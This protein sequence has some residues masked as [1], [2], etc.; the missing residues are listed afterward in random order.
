VTGKEKL[1]AIYADE[2]VMDLGLAQDFC[3]ETSIYEP[4]LAKA[5]VKTTEMEN[6]PWFHSLVMTHPLNWSSLKKN[7]ILLIVAA[8]SFLPNY[9]SA[10][11]AAVL[12]VRSM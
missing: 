5:N 6:S 8:T 1:D 4:S 7:S 10:T 2:A 12:E 9:R 11:G 3:G